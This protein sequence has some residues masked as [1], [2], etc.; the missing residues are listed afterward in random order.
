M[1]KMD[2]K[3]DTNITIFG[4]SFVRDLAKVDRVNASR[5]IKTEQ[6]TKRVTYYYFG[7][8]SFDYFLSDPRE[9][10]LNEVTMSNPDILVV[11]LGGNSITSSLSNSQVL[12]QSSVFYEKLFF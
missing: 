9:T 11:H 3:K 5:V 7:G 12:K 6:G 2:V 1:G 10:I 4:S 8:K